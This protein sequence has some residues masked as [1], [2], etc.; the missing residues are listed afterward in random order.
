MA[1]GE[2]RSDLFD[3]AVEMF[4]LHRSVNE[5]S[6]AIGVPRSTVKRW[7]R[8]SKAD[9]SWKPGPSHGGGAG[10]RA[11][12]GGAARPPAHTRERTE[13]A[14]LDSL[15]E[16][17]LRL[18]LL[19]LLAVPPLKDDPVGHWKAK[20]ARA[21]FGVELAILRGASGVS[22]NWARVEDNRAKKLE[23]ALA[24]AAASE[25]DAEARGLRD[26][27]ALARRLLKRIPALCRVCPDLAN[28]MRLAIEAALPADVVDV[29]EE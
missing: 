15:D 7:K 2:D 16:D 8:Q 13:I 28:D 26:P 12:P 23:E 17:E 10:P 14:D 19:E 27:A 4:G 9:P 25:A 3:Q 18:V 20:R 6:Q 29:E 24:H 5:V 1:R 21:E 22:V 11:R